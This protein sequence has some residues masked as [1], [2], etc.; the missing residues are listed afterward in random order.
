MKIRSIVNGVGNLSI[1]SGAILLFGIVGG[2]DFEEVSG[3]H[4]PLEEYLRWGVL[5]VLLMLYGY[6][7]KEAFK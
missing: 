3:V 6:F 5:G 4:V 7:S 1:I 2:M